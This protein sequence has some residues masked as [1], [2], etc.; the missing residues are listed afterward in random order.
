MAEEGEKLTIILKSSDD[1]DFEVDIKVAKMS[2]T[3]KNILDGTHN[4]CVLLSD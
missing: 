4:T 2:E 3:I 1:K